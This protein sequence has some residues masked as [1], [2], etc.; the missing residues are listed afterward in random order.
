MPS[1]LSPLRATAARQE[2]LRDVLAGL[3]RAEK[4]LPCKYFYDQR[5]SELF[6]RI[7]ELEEYYHARCELAILRERAGEIAALL[8]PA[9]ALIEYG[10]GSS[11]KTRLL[12]DRMTAGAYLPVDISRDHLLRAAGQLA[13]DYP[14]LQV[15]PIVADF[16]QPFALPAVAGRRVVYFSGST[17]S[18]FAPADAVRL[19]GQIARQVGPGGGLVIG[20]DLKKDRSILEPAYDDAQGVTARFNKNLL[21]RINRELGGS[22]DLADWTHRARV[23]DG[24]GRVEIGLVCRRSCDVSIAAL[25]RSFRFARGDFIHTEDSTK[26]SQR[27][28]AEL[29]AAASLRIDARWLDGGR[30]FCVALLAPL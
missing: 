24:G 6:D 13:A 17:I 11:V 2:F 16:S 25:G 23:V 15:V 18:N 10:S 21:A 9:P 8:G 14:H 5:G 30:R 20:V 28:V 7:C 4:T 22:F 1:H 27:E 3:A 19:L 26:Y 12:L 29:A